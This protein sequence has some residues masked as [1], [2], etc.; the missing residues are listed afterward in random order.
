[1]VSIG[2]GALSVGKSGQVILING[3]DGLANAMDSVRTRGRGQDV[4][5][6]V[7]KLGL[8][9]RR[10][11]YP[12][13]LAADPSGQFR[14]G[15]PPPPKIS[16]TSPALAGVT[17]SFDKSFVDKIVQSPGS[18]VLLIVLILLLLHRN[19]AVSTL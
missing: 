3:G 9:R 8:E 18:V 15:F 6:P 11:I 16:Y 19:E 2:Q 5:S 7:Q 4:S 1:M 10:E 12:Q 13:P 14:A 17:G